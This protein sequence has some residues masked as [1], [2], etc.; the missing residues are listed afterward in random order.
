MSSNC[1]CC[2]DLYKT[3]FRFLNETD[4]AID[5][6]AM[7]VTHVYLTGVGHFK[8]CFRLHGVFCLS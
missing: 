1:N 4:T 2:S 3:A 6:Y 5:I 8:G 7:A